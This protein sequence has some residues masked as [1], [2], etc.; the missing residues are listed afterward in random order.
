MKET[1]LQYWLC[2]YLCYHFTSTKLYIFYTYT[3]SS[4]YEFENEKLILV[5]SPLTSPF[6]LF[7][8]ILNMS[9]AILRLWLA[10]LNIHQCNWVS[11]E[12]QKPS[13]GKS[14][15]LWPFS[16]VNIPSANM[17]E[18]EFMTCTTR[19]QSQCFGFTP[20]SR[21]P[22]LYTVYETTLATSGI[23]HLSLSYKV[24]CWVM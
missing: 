24:T 12:W 18:V 5:A 15:V 19:G 17:E 3:V 9:A 2:K 23:G 7:I 1:M 20:C 14:I 16:L 8:C 4:V 21:H 11:Q 6:P 22:S 13:L 10:C